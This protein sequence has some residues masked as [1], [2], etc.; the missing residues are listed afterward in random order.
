MFQISDSFSR[1]VLNVGLCE[2]FYIFKVGG[3]LVIT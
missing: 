1:N 2:E 3:V